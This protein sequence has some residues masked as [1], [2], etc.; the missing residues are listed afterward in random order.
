MRD[1]L[2]AAEPAGLADE[3][4]HPLTGVEL[5][6]ANPERRRHGSNE[7]SE[8]VLG[9][10]P[11]FDFDPMTVGGRVADQSRLRRSRPGE[12][13]QAIRQCRA[14]GA[15]EPRAARRQLIVERLTCQVG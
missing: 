6:V 8:A 15:Y 4:F 9:D 3:S 12:R 11:H 7:A 13:V 10:R 14:A 5:Y 1:L 2:R